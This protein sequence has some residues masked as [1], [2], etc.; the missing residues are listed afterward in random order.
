MAIV[1]DDYLAAAQK[2]LEDQ[3][4]Q[5][6]ADSNKLYDSQRDALTSQY[7]S[8]LSGVEGAYR[9]S[10]NE[11]AVQK[12]I[13][14]RQVAENMANL[15]LTDS[16][17]NRTQQ[18]AIQLSY[19]NNKANLDRQK[20]SQ[21]DALNL[22]KAQGLAT[23]DQNRLAGQSDINQYYANLAT[24]NATSAYNEAVKQQAALEEARIQAENEYN[25]AQ[26]KYKYEM[27]QKQA[28]AKKAQLATMRETFNG[29]SQYDKD[30]LAANIRKYAINNEIGEDELSQMLA[31]FDLSAD[32]YYRYLGTGS[33]Y[34]SPSEYK[35]GSGAEVKEWNYKT[36]G[37]LNYEFEIIKNTK[38]WFGG[39]DN[40][41]IVS[42]YYPDGTVV[43]ENVRVDQL[44]N[45]IRQT[46]TDLIDKDKKDKK[47][48]FVLNTN[49]NG[50]KFD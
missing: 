4:N 36:D 34:V 2:Y 25:L 47:G 30:Q 40:N 12:L 24:Q 33:V 42:I 14:E 20:Q 11:N 9:D 17:L 35:K 31:E 43:A 15:G 6:L 13:N 5:A 7:D 49:L 28:E 23:I 38:N 3:K 44:P 8:Q 1:Y 39:V 18:T 50:S 32:E 10:Y 48:Y 27:L 22:Q 45:S 37:P 26:L 21:I 41:D 29:N 46:V 16:G 19:A